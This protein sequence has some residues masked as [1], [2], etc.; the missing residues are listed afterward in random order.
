MKLIA[1]LN[2]LV[3]KVLQNSTTAHAP[4]LICI[5]SKEGSAKESGG[6]GGGRDNPWPW[7]Y[8]LKDIVQKEQSLLI[9]YYP[10]SCSS[11]DALV[12]VIYHPQ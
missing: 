1:Q 8:D 7:T 5:I 6:W 4:S 12:S 3:F 11:S 2:A 10:L 9:V